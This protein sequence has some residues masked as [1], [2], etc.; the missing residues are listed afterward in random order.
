MAIQRNPVAAPLA[1]ARRQLLELGGFA[2]A[3][4]PAA[5]GLGRMPRAVQYNSYGE[6]AAGLKVTS[7][8]STN[9]IQI[10]LLLEIESNHITVIAC[11]V[12][13]LFIT[14]KWF[15]RLKS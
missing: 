7:A 11:F 6:G 4:P 13:L 2:A 1:S 15:C 9:C 14:T 3:E 5:E 8:R 10:P 12:Q